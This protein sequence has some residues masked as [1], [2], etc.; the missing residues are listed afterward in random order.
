MKCG[1]WTRS[2]SRHLQ[3]PGIEVVDEKQ[4]QVPGVPICLLPH[5]TYSP[6]FFVQLFSPSVA[7]LSNR[8]ARSTSRCLDAKPLTQEP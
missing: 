4:I 5:F 1:K 2:S 7:L 6:P 8:D 3:E